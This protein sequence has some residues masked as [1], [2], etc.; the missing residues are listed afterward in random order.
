MKNNRTGKLDEMQDQKLLK[1]EEYGFWIMF[2]A[3]LV[4][5]VV[6]LFAGAGIKQIIGE[7]IV[8]LI[9]S[10]YLSVTTL[11]NGLWTR[12]AAPSRKGNAI[13]SIVPAVLLGV[14]N[15]IRLA[16]KNGITAKAL[17]I[18]AGIMIA[19]YAACYI[20]LELFRASYNKR[21]AELDETDEES[22]GEY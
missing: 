5:I 6:Q 22:E 2:W 8:L 16:Q 1:L 19:A 7:I 3:L 14:I 18:V 9:G 20:I 11:R 15:V 4:S 13:T 12:T 21:R 17:L 10:I